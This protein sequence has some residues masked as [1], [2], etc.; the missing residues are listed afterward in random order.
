VRAERL[1]GRVFER[2]E[3]VDQNPRRR[4]ADAAEVG[5]QRPAP[6]ELI[7]GVDQARQVAGGQRGQ[8]R[9]NDRRGWSGHGRGKVRE[10]VEVLV[11][12]RQDGAGFG[13]QDGVGDAQATGDAARPRGE[14]VG[15]DARHLP[16][17]V[18]LAAD[19]LREGR[20]CGVFEKAHHVTAYA[21]FRGPQ[22]AAAQVLE[23]EHAAADA[24]GRAV[25]AVPELEA[26]VGNGGEGDEEAAGG[27]PPAEDEERVD[28]ALQRGG[29]EEDVGRRRRR[30]H[31]CLASVLD[32]W[33]QQ[34]LQR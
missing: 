13:P 32:S 18:R 7:G 10:R 22:A 26:G 20:R 3:G 24:D 28:V 21:V 12:Q 2:V 34:A 23:A 25:V 14:G 4:L 6:D 9:D 27:E 19:E 8:S 16:P 33:R 29:D 17:G 1:D 5:E 15:H 11:V 30:R 31:G